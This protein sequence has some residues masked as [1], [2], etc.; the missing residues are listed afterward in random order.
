MQ[1]IM[2]YI[3][4]FIL[5]MQGGHPVWAENYLLNGGQ[6][7]TF[8]YALVQEIR[9]TGETV[10]MNLTYVIP[11]TFTSET[12]RQQIKDFDIRFSLKPDAQKEWTDRH[13]NRVVD[14][15]WDSP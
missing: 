12:Y 1:K 13:G 7:S 15:A 3:L 11:Q 6:K 8:R 5:F 4:G 9:P 2:I 10:T 14:Y